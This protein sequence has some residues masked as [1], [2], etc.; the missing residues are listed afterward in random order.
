MGAS[1]L[2]FNI[3]RYCVHDGP[4]IRTVVF[5][6]GCP[7]RCIWCSNPEGQNPF[8]EILYYEDR[9]KRC[10]L[11]ATICPQGAIELRGGELAINRRKCDSCGKCAESCPNG[12][13]KMVGEVKGAGEVLEVVGRDMKFYRDSGGGITLSGGEPLYQ[14]DFSI[15]IVKGAKRMRIDTAIE[16]CGHAPWE[17]AIK[18]LL[19]YADLIL[20]DVKHSDPEAHRRYTGESNELILRNLKLIDAYGK[21]MVISIP[22]IPTV[23]MFEGVIRGIVK[24]IAD[25]KSVEGVAL[26][27]YHGFGAPKYKLL[28]RDYQLG[29]I[30]PVGEDELSYYKELI[31]DA[32]SVPVQV[33]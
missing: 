14:P 27:P 1:G 9:C 16:T 32:L 8:P 23:N 21:R 26:R 15:E 30:N 22:L 25:L 3:Q 13:L 5:L 33:A 4:G 24:L 18:P 17:G 31:S 7:L 6:K 2:I 19:P 10:S 20:Y 29:H 28:G 11:C 12:A